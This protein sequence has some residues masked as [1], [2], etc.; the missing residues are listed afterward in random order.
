MSAI[1]TVITEKTDTN[2]YLTTFD[3]NGNEIKVYQPE[4]RLESDIINHGY[5]APLFVVFGDTR[6]CKKEAVSFAEES[7]LSLLAQENGA[8]IVF[9]DPKTEWQE[10]VPGVYE[11][12]MNKTKIKQWGFSH[13]MLYDDKKPRNRFEEMA[14]KNDPNFDP[15]P[16]YFIFASPVATYVYGFGRGG[17]YLAKNYLRKISGKA[18]MGDL[19]F[20]D[21]T[22]TGITLKDLS[23]TPDVSCDDVSIVSIA[24]SKQINDVFLSTKNRVSIYDQL[25]VIAQYDDCL[26]DYK[27]W[28]GKIRKSVNYRKEGIH[29]LPQRMTVNV[30]PDNQA[31]KDPTQEVGYVLFYGDDLDLHDDKDRFPLLLCF[32]GGGDTAIATA[33]IGQWPEI[34]KENRFMLCAVE[35]HLKVTANETMQIV[36][37]LCENYAID[38]SRIY[39]TGFSM[40]GIKSWDFYQEY[41][42][43]MA[44]IAPMCATVDVGENTQ[45][46]KSA[47]VNEDT[48]LPVFYVG[49]EGSPL[50]ELPLQDKKC[51]NR[52]AYTFKINQVRTPYDVS[53]EDKEKWEDPIYGVKGDEQKVLHDEDFPESVTTVRD[54][55]SEDGKIYTRLVSVSEQKHE[56]RPFTCRL[57]WDFL[58]QYRRNEEGK[59][60]ITG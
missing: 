48:L 60:E 8:V 2:G 3:L 32:H 52:I 18:S 54:F 7:K 49:G 5:S 21:I 17:D 35:M 22:M 42:E 57:A 6:F 56:I 40:G 19:G 33:I 36:K 28:A 34:A 23:V 50:A 29:M 16:E 25:D 1:R 59:I 43:V 13:G 14:M 9:V 51:V 47:K 30:S 31:V 44:A 39:A 53:F 10:E 58:K 20:A 26:G 55:Y 45:F 24:N 46:A 11:E 38:P 27:R 41:P 37:H 15:E 4:D 12:L